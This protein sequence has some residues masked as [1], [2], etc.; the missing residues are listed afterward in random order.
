MNERSYSQLSRLSTFEERFDYLSLKGMVAERTF[1]GE[2]WM[3]QT[4]YRSYEW[5]HVRQVVIARDLGCDLGIE[6]YD[7]FDKVIIHHMNPIDRDQIAHADESILD[8]EFLITVTHNTHN[9]IH[10]GDKSKLLTMPIER[11]PGDHILWR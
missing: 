6:G 8:P 11:R 5:K 3:N 10:Y 9:A 4:F 2:R 7:I 1:G